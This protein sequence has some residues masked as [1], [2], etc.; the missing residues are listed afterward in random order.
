M[1]NRL[2]LRL[3]LALA[4]GFILLATLAVLSFARCHRNIPDSEVQTSMFNDHLLQ[5]EYPDQTTRL[6]SRKTGNKVTQRLDRIY[7]PS[8]ENSLYTVFIK[9]GKRGYLNTLNGDVVIRPQFDFAWQFIGGLAAVVT[10]NK[11]GF[12]NDKGNFVIPPQFP[13]NRKHYKDASFLFYDGFCPIPD[14]TGLLGLI[15]T[16]GKIIMQPIY[17]EVSEPV[18]GFRVVKQCGGNYGLLGGKELNLVLAFEYISIVV[19]EEG[20]LCCKE[21]SYQQLLDF[22]LNVE[23]KNVFDSVDKI[24][25]DNG[26]AEQD[27][28][29]DP[30]L[31]DSGYSTY[32]VNSKCGLLDCNGKILSRPYWDEIKYHQPGIFQA[33]LSSAYLLIDKYGRPVN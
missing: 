29:G 6:V 14:S 33:R 28:D 25:I 27:E 21:N 17:D 15:D 23:L 32:T 8:E 20:I 11:L 18:N 31:K 19:D 9:N 2:S 26:N 1:K 22:N 24:Y 3:T 30:I 7:R 13:F 5:I 4:I 16:T 12:I 10:K